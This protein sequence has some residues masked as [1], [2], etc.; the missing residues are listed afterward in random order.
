MLRGFPVEYGLETI[1]RAD[2]G[3][4]RSSGNATAMWVDAEARKARGV[5]QRQEAQMQDA[6]ATVS[7]TV[8]VIAVAIAWYTHAQQRRQSHLAL[9]IALHHDLTSGE[10]A[11]A[12]DLLGRLIYN[13]ETVKDVATEDLMA[14]YFT[15]LWCFERV[16]AGERSMREHNRRLADRSRTT[17]PL[18]FL[19]DCI[20]WHVHEAHRY[21]NQVRSALTQRLGKAPDD[22][23]SISAVAHLVDVLNTAGYAD[24][25]PR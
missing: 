15:V 5:Q 16:S 13:A 12:R 7:A 6:L 21:R 1:A 18:R 9:A 10:V 19:Y 4:V 20:H 11:A 3:P 25:R 14:A 8:A 17:P 24:G 23:L 22:A 2:N